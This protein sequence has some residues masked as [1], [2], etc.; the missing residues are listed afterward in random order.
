MGKGETT[1]YHY[2]PLF[3]QCFQGSQDKGVVWYGGNFFPEVVWYGGYFFPD[4]KVL[5]H[6]KSIVR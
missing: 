2:F 3:Q 4:D 1:G 6:I 5:D